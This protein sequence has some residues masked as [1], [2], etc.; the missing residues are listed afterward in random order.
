MWF[1]NVYFMTLMGVNDD[2]PNT[3]AYILLR[4][5]PMKSNSF[6]EWMSAQAAIYSI[7]LVARL[8]VCL[9]LAKS[10]IFSLVCWSVQFV[11]G[12]VDL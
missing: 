6:T 8:S 10:F 7:I 12:F 3:A 5:I 2:R 4:Q 1:A 9:V 11:C